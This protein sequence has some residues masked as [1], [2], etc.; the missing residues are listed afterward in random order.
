[1]RKIR[2]F[3]R[4]LPAVIFLIPARVRAEEAQYPAPTGFVSDFAGILSSAATS[5][6]T[7][8]LQELRDKTS[9]EVAVYIVK[10]TAPETIEGYAVKRFQTWRW[11]G[12]SEDGIGKKGKDNGVLL[13]AAIDDRKVRIEVGYGLEG[14]IPDAVAKR[15]IETLIT[16]RFREMK[17]GEG[18]AAAV[19]ALAARIS[20]EGGAAASP[21]PEGRPASASAAN[22]IITLA[23]FFG[24]AG[25]IVAMVVL[26]RR[27]GKSGGSGGGWSSRSSGGSSGWSGGSSG[28]GGSS[29]GGSGGG[30]SGGGGASG[31]W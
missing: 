14:A 13:M 1:M 27:G 17:Y 18:I 24:I 2:L 21:T 5:S 4:F 8:T 6:I 26:A 28:S 10:T 25:F 3:L 31:S 16:P 30:R 7:D 19:A 11:P 9:A 20:G 15:I 23:I 29:F 22:A 12:A